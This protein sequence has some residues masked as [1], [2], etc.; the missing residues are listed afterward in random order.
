MSL[1]DS[2]TIGA[3]NSTHPPPPPATQSCK[4][5]TALEKLF[6]EDNV[7]IKLD[8]DDFKDQSCTEHGTF[9][10]WMERNCYEH[11]THVQKARFFQ[12]TSNGIDTL[13]SIL[14]SRVN[15][16]V[17]RLR[18]HAKNLLIYRD[19][20]VLLQPK[21]SPGKDKDGHS[22]TMLDPDWID[23]SIA[24]EWMKK[25]FKEHESKC[26]DPK[27]KFVSP[28]WLIDTK[29]DCLVP[30]NDS[31]PFVALSYR[32]GS[33][34]TL[35]M[36]KDVF[37][38]LKSPGS[39]S[40]NNV[41]IT[42]TV[43]DA[44]HTVRIIGERYLWVDAVCIAPDDEKQLAAQLQLMGGIYSSAKLT[45]VVLDGDARSG[46]KGL[47]SQSSKRKLS[48]ILPWKDKSVVVRQLPALSAQNV[49]AS[50]YFQRGWTFQEYTLSQRRL[51]FGDQQ[52]HWQCSCSTS[53]EDLPR[54]RD[55]VHTLRF[56]NIKRGWLDFHELGVLLNEYNNRELT[57][58]EDAFPAVNGLL[59][60]LERYSFEHGFLF[61]LPRAVFDAALMWSDNIG[62]IDKFLEPRPGLCR[63]QPSERHHSI[64]PNTYLPSWSWIGW[65]GGNI[66]MLDTEAQF[67][68]S[69]RSLDSGRGQLAKLMRS[70][71]ITIPITQWYN[72]ASPDG[73]DKQ[74]IPRY[75]TVYKE[76]PE[77]AYDTEVWRVKGPIK[78][79]ACIPMG[80]GGK[81]IYE[82]AKFPGRS[83]L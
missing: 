23:L 82:H 72:H 73:T 16:K 11:F 34:T 10:Q 25:C 39:L 83:F 57:F 18:A 65:R 55:R 76:S 75:P 51:I 77:I 47:N 8:K 13:G 56:P 2:A 45:I 17:P 27:E 36:N 74:L 61:G 9:F 28:A 22:F 4:L 67:Q 21:T 59:T 62:D 44:I 26:Q 42:A 78:D 20:E 30:G 46:I 33:S 66:D 6:A 60:Y 38:N 31:R 80:V 64:L 5:C 70:S 19:Y 43:Q 69:R 29:D 54:I 32:W 15:G 68:W 14:L 50:E 3:I 24:K 40:L 37:E 12:F 52:I 48:N 1:V 53:H 79:E 41:S 7:E 63:R 71:V 35:Q 49:L 81:H 58:P